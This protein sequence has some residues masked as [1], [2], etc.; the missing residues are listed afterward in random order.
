MSQT[1]DKTFNLQMQIYHSF[2]LRYNWLDNYTMQEYSKI[3]KGHLILRAQLE[4]HRE[5]STLSEKNVGTH[6]PGDQRS[7]G[8][9]K[10]NQQLP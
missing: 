6:L 10:I 4:V 1:W 5:I 9:G 3:R 2:P 8:F 7:S